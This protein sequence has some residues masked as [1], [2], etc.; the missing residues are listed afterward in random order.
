M[1]EW[2]YSQ[3]KPSSDFRK[4]LRDRIEEAY[5]YRTE[6]TKEEQKRLVKL[7]GIA[8]RLKRGENEQNVGCTV[9]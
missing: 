8:Q 6:L 3:K 9:G 2:H 5:P 1:S 4:L 7:E